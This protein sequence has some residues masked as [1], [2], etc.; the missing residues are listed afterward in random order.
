MASKARTGSVGDGGL[1][2]GPHSPGAATGTGNTGLEGMMDSIL[3][4]APGGNATA[5]SAPAGQTGGLGGLLEELGRAGRAGTTTQ[6]APQGGGSLGDLLGGLAGSGGLGGLLGSLA[7]Q[8]QG[9]TAQTPQGSF[10]DVL[11]SQFGST[12]EKPK[13]PTA[14]QEVAAGLMLTAMIQAA[15]ADG[16]FD[17][18]EHDKLIGKLGDVSPEE[19]AF[20]QAQ[21][22]KPV[23]VR[24]LA[25]QVPA[26]LEMQVYAMSVMGID[27]DSQEEA[28]YLHQLATEMA[29]DKQT[30]NNIHAKLGVPK[31]Y[32]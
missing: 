26:G 22:D 20:V 24:G 1:F 17:K 29:L 4:G 10:G 23:D 11:N 21:L 8:M 25:G 5:N 12:P 18:G 2:G 28:Q 3:G 14:D 27:L 19:R 16:K 13:K 32:N 30:V 9:N 15:K 6:Q 31:L 7:G